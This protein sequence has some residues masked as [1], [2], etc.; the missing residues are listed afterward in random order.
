MRK[1]INKDYDPG[2]IDIFSTAAT[3]GILKIGV[4]KGHKKTKSGKPR[5]IGPTTKWRKIIRGPR[6]A[7]DPTT[8]TPVIARLSKL[9]NDCHLGEVTLEFYVYI[10][11]GVLRMEELIHK[12]LHE[13]AKDVRRCAVCA[14]GHDE[15]FRVEFAKAM[16]VTK[17]W[18]DFMSLEPY[19]EYGF[20]HEF[21][22][23]RCAG[24]TA[25]NHANKTVKEW[26]DNEFQKALCDA[27]ECRRREKENKKKER[28]GEIRRRKF[29]RDE[30]LMFQ[31]K[32]VDTM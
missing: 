19:G 31:M 14:K 4:A 6:L 13:H 20:I 3:P 28:E 10:S 2:W 7:D 8:P 5:D 12:T 26:F 29:G 22:Q 24:L 25:E 9:Q 1:P 15:W 18:H 30:P 16:S 21:W 17:V 11:K 23:S 32:R 27:E